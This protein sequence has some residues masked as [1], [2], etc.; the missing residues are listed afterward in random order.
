MI[1]VVDAGLGN[2][3]SVVRALEAT[4]TRERVE[5]VSAPEGLRDASRV[6]VPGQGAFGDAAAALRPDSPLGAAI[7]DGVR[8]GKPYLGICL[9]MQVLFQ[10]SEESPG[11]PGFGLYAGSVR[12]LPSGLVDSTGRRLK[13]P[14]IGWSPIAVRGGAHPALDVDDPWFY[15]V[16]SFHARPDDESLIAAVAAFGGTPITA[17]VARGNVLGV[18]FHPEKSQRAGQKFL[19]AWMASPC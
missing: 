14:H 19:R 9:G 6:V 18:Q 15:F 2:L 11:H 7:L 3:R 4:G 13:V 12:R 10:S 5:L 17:A 1:A 8:A 16:H